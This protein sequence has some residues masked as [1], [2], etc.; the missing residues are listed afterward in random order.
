MRITNSQIAQR[1]MRQ[2]I[3][4]EVEEFWVMALNS[5]KRILATECLFRGTVDACM[6]HPRDIFRFACRHNAS[7]LI[8]A[9]SH[10]SGDAFPS[11]MDL[12]M[13]EKLMI[14]SEIFQIPILDHVILTKTSYLSFLDRGL[15]PSYD[16]LVSAEHSTI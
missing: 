11:D 7:G 5:G 12:L 8:L 10:P 16:S 1:K 4:F 9:H 14:A 13:T 6:I 2:V 3:N 15:L